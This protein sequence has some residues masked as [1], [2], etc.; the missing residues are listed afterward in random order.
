VFDRTVAVTY[1]LFGGLPMCAIAL[2][3]AAIHTQHQLTGRMYRW[4]A[5]MWAVATLLGLVPLGAWFGPYG[6]WDAS[7]QAA[8]IGCAALLLLVLAVRLWRLPSKARRLLA[9][10]V[11]L[12]AALFATVLLRTLILEEQPSLDAHA[13]ALVGF[14]FNACVTS[15]ALLSAIT[16]HRRQHGPR[17]VPLSLLLPTF[18]LIACLLFVMTIETAYPEY[19]AY[20]DAARQRPG[21]DGDW[22]DIWGMLACRQLNNWGPIHG[23]EYLGV[24][25]VEVV[26]LLPL[27]AAGLA[28]GLFVGSDLLRRVPAC[29]WSWWLAAV[30]VLLSTTQWV[31]IGLRL[32]RPNPDT[33]ALG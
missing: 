18:N 25:V 1:V 24:M 8:A 27:F 9:W 20:L 28:H 11:A 30:F 2:L 4:I 21:G 7:V 19:L 14:F 16:I 6:A 5:T 13:R 33:S 22:S 32:D 26:N 3:L 31:L 15:L 12:A 17:R 29:E 23:G 10:G